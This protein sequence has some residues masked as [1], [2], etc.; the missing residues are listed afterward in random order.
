M[1]E[2]LF[3]LGRDRNLAVL[4]LESVFSIDSV[5]KVNNQFA[6]VETDKKIDLERF[7]GITKFGRRINSAEDVIFDKGKLSYTAAGD[8]KLLLELKSRFK[9]ERIKATFRKFNFEPRNLDYEFIK[10]DNKLFLVDE[11]SDPKKYR[12]RD[13]NRPRFDAK[14]VISIRMAK[15]LINFSKAEKEILDPFCGNGTILQEGLFRGFHVIGVDQHIKESLDILKWV[16]KQFQL[17]SKFTLIPGD[18]KNLEKIEKVECC[19]TEPYLGPYFKKLPSSSKGKR[20]IRSLAS[21]YDGLFRELSR[22]VEKRVVIIIPAI[23]TFNK[24]LEVDFKTILEKHGFKLVRSNV[25]LPIAYNNPR[26]KV[27][28]EIWVL[29]RLE[30]L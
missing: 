10:F 14:K 7:G 17:Q 20:V 2:Y 1:T 22:K 25:E 3:V 16:K 6:I 29:E 9:E 24:I 27:L 5:K 23:R 18:A 4:E 13:E 21:L 12:F 11:R 15:M 19:V 28:R 30:K 26:A 8:K